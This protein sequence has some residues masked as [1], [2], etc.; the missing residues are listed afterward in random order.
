[1]AGNFDAE[2]FVKNEPLLVNHAI[3]IAKHFLL[4]ADG[5]EAGF[6]RVG[7]VNSLEDIRVDVARYEKDN[8]EQQ[9]MLYEV[10]V[11]LIDVKVNGCKLLR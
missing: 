8:P 7:Q 4:E 9:E 5:I 3:S 10:S 11:D 6:A 2:S 1:M